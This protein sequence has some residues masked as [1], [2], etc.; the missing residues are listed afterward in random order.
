MIT[1]DY[2]NMSDTNSLLNTLT[3]LLDD[4]KAI[5]IVHI[6]VS[7]QTT[8]TDYML[9]CSGRSS[10]HVKAIAESLM[11]QMKTNGMPATHHN[12]LMGGEW[13][14]IDFG[15]VIVHVMQPE[16]RSFYHLEDLWQHKIG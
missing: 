6:D 16:T 9:I 15:D 8:I 3:S 14:I 1:V 10:R 13:V 12:G 2:L 4:A 7:T 5:D 11:E